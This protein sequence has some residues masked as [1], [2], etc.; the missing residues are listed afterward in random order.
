MEFRN[1]LKKTDLVHIQ[2]MLESTGFFYESE[3][4]IAL[5]LVQENLDKGE[6]ISGY[7]FN[8]A[9]EHK[10]PI[11]YSCYGNIPGTESS[12]DLYW[13]VVHQSFRGKGIGK[14]LMDMLVADIKKR[15]GQTIWIETSSRPL[16]EPTRQFYLSYGCK[17]V[18][19]LPEFYGK[20][21]SK[22]IFNLKC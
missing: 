9:E 15:G 5:E 14:V 16:Y 12:F 22:L 2:E 6:E 11:A 19:E 1:K 3:V 7:I 21:D 18:A 10:R 13:I 4:D 17:M 8:M 20:N